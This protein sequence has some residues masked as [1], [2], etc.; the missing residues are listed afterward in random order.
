MSETGAR[1]PWSVERRLEFIEF[2]L[3]WDGQVNRSDL[4]EYFGISVPQASADLGRYQELAGSNLRYDKRVK[5]YVA[6]PG[7]KPVL[8][9]PTARHYLAQLRSIADEVLTPQETWLG[10]Q[11]AFAVV[12]PVRR[13]LEAGKLRDILTAIRTCA[14]IRVRYQS[15]SRPQPTWRWI[16]PH[17][18]GFDGFRWHARSW[19]HK[20]MDF[21]DF[22]LARVLSI[23]DRRP[24]NLD[25]SS[26]LEWQLEVTM[27]LG[28]HPDMQERLRR[29]IELDYGMVNGVVEVQT[30]VCLSYYLERHLGLDLDPKLVPPP[31]QQIVLLNRPEVEA[32]RQATQAASGKLHG[33]R[34]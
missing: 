34:R 33:R 22:V 3:F 15:F 30:R 14:A 25:P 12:P 11:P 8:T 18:L 17:A 7:F 23:S 29:A 1:M 9:T 5:A 21:R 32:V 10:W 2:R 13:K 16:T 31:R 20:N 27:R 24:D 19:C 26:D 4:V 28:P 6:E